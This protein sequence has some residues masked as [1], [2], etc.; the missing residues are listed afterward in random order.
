MLCEIEEGDE[1]ILPSFNSTSAAN[2]V[3]KRGARIV[4]VDVRSDTLT[5]DLDLV[6]RA[7]TDRT[8]AIVP[9]HYSGVSCDMER[10]TA[11]A[12]SK[13]VFVVEDVAEGLNAKYRGRCLGT[14][15]D[16]GAFSFH[17]TKDCTCG[18]GG[19]FVTSSEELLERAEI[20]REKGTD[21][22]KFFRGQVD[23]YTWIDVGS[24]YVPSDIVAA[25]LCAQLERIEQITSKRKEIYQYY[26]SGLEPLADAGKVTLPTVPEGC[27]INFH[28]FFLLTKDAASRTAMIEHL[29]AQGI[30]AV[31]HFLPLHTSPMGRRLGYEEGQF[32]I[33]EDVSRRVLRL[34]FFHELDLREV[35]VVVKAIRSFFDSSPAR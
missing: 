11:F 15:G 24:S 23:R 25:F 4:F 5:L 14:I 30:M 28:K 16:M 12:R 19:A 22:S 21:R 27:E 31:F 33:T 9:R 29:K 17:E 3:L 6:E 32:P 34:P 13:G 20:I 8:K 2:S 18:E 26:L 35:E 10:L 1:V 7:T